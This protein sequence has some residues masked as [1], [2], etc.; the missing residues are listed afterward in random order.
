MMISTVTTSTISVL[1]TI[2]YSGS[3][4]II[5]IMILLVLLVQKELA[6]DLA[7]GWQRQ[8]SQVFNVSVVPLLITFFLIVFFN[9]T[10]VFN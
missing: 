2:Q 8:F 7:E 5:A 3:L 6:K 1:T 9:I 10:K 4:A